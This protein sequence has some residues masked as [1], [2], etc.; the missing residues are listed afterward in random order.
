MSTQAQDIISTKAFQQLAQQ[1]GSWCYAAVERIIKLAYGVQ[2]GTQREIAENYWGIQEANSIPPRLPSGV[3]QTT[4]WDLASDQQRTWVAEN[5]WGNPNFEGVTNATQNPGP[6]TQTQV[7]GIIDGGNLFVYGTQIHWKVVYGYRT[8][9]SSMI[10]HLL[11]WD[12]Y[13]GGSLTIVP[14]SAYS[15]SAGQPSISF[16]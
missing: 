1:T 10:T 6:F 5:N 4:Y 13:D 9:S 14:W 12:P 2:V 15:S 8:N 3:T 16:G 7:R 11:C